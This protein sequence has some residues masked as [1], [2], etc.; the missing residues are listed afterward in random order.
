MWILLIFLIVFSRSHRSVAVLSIDNEIAN[1]PFGME[2]KSSEWVKYMGYFLRKY[3]LTRPV[4]ISC[5]ILGIADK[6]IPDSMDL[7][8]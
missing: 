2:G 8:R 4:G 7:T 3:D 1:Q 6:L 5:H